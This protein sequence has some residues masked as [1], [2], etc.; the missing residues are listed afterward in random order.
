MPRGVKVG[1]CSVLDKVDLW[2]AI[3]RERQHE[4]GFG[5]SKF[6]ELTKDHFYPI[7]FQK[8]R[9]NEFMQSQ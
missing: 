4:P 5:W 1:F 6:K 7:S 8:A 3:V 9:E 2:W